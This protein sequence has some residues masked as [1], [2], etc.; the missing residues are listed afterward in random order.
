MGEERREGIGFLLRTRTCV[1]ALVHMPT[2]LALPLILLLGR[3]RD[4][5]RKCVVNATTFIAARAHEAQSTDNTTIRFREGSLSRFG[6]PRWV[7]CYN[8]YVMQARGAWV[9]MVGHLIEKV[10]LK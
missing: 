7:I 8:I 1:A 5:N 2:S 10:T 3:M 6:Q 4:A 9:A